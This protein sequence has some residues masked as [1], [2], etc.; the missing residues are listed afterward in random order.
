V[1]EW[2]GVLEMPHLNLKTIAQADIQAFT[3]GQ[4]CGNCP[5]G[6]IVLFEA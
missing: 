4:A 6:K 1:R 2:K 3:R 5:M